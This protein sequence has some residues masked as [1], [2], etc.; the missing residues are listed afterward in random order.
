M[1]GELDWIGGT[2]RAYEKTARRANDAR[3][4]ATVCAALAE[5]HAV[6]DAL[7]TP[8]LTRRDALFEKPEY[9]DLN[10]ALEQFSETLRGVSFALGA[11]ALYSWVDHHDFEVVGDSSAKTLLAVADQL[12]KPYP[13][14]ME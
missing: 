8:L 2:V 7:A 1:T 5:A 4:A 6:A 10:S 3:D 14:W 13:A 11:E 9:D 12:I